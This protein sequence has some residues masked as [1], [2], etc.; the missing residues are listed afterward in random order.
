M[1]LVTTPIFTVNF[2]PVGLL[3]E[4]FWQK[5][6]E[7]ISIG[8]HIKKTGCVDKLEIFML[9]KFYKESGSF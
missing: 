9:A 1:E 6:T 7:Q 8:K 5:D 3:T 4:T 2:C